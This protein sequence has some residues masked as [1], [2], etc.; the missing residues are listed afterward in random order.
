[1]R[2]TFMVKLLALVVLALVVAGCGGSSTAASPDKTV[3]LFMTRILRE[4]LNGQWARQWNDLHPAH[5]QLITRAQYVAC[6]RSM[7]TNI[8]TGD[9]TYRVL[10]VKDEP[11]D[12][13]AVPQRDSKVVTIQYR[14]PL[15]NAVPRYD[16]HAVAVD[17]RWTWILGKRFLEAVAH[18]KCM[19]GSALKR[20][21]RVLA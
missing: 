7:G 20:S 14:S 11:I 9:E 8:G 4:E 1:M 12:V 16:M 18:G 19:D 13:F 5:K 6:S 10:A 15:S 17:G 3:G 2:Y 21:T